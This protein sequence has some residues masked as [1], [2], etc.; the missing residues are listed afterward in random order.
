MTAVATGSRRGAI[1]GVPVA[2]L[3]VWAALYGI[4]GI[5]PA[6]PLVGG[7]TFGG[8]EFILVLAGVLFGPIA[9]LVAA[10]VGGI[11]ASFIA[12]ATAYFGLLTFYPHSIAALTAGLL[13][14]NTR[15]SRL[16]A[17]AL[18]VVMV[19]AWPLVPPFSTIGRPVYADFA[20]WP[21]YLTAI[22]G[23]L[24]S[25]WAVRQIRTFDSRRVTLGLAVLSWTVYMVNHLAVSLGYSYLYPEGPDQWVFAFRSGIVP[26]QR[27]LLAVVGTLL[28]SA[29]IVGLHRAG[30]R[31]PA[32]SG[33]VL[34]SDDSRL[35]KPA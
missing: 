26:G 32:S 4:A 29:L 23:F 5:L 24:L 35:R 31:F 20:Y 8:Q 7:G 6:I 21:M 27:L 28:G 15:T 14:R 11:V 13:V 30:I 33:S 3:A 25:P 19:L 10:T 1:A 2:Y 12:P 16:V 18:F 9:G 17:F 34:S 22:P